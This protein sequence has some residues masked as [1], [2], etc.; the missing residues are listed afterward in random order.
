[1]TESFLSWGLW[2]SLQDDKSICLQDD[3]PIYLLGGEWNKHVYNKFTFAARLLG[4]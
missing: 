4:C 2:S 3:T 1:M